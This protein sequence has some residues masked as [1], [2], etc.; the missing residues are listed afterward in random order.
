LSF[1]AQVKDEVASA[2]P[3]T[4]VITAGTAT[5]PRRSRR[6]P[7]PLSETLSGLSLTE[8]SSSCFEQLT[9]ISSQTNRWV[10]C[11]VLRNAPMGCGNHSLIPGKARLTVAKFSKAGGTSR[12]ALGDV[13]APMFE[14]E[15]AGACNTGQES[16]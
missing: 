16:G 11:E 8:I 12:R 7:T 15:Y 1:W 13:K 6:R 5:L 10:A 3:L 4:R 9:Q 2:L 14:L